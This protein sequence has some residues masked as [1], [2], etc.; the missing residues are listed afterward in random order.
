MNLSVVIPVYNESESLDSLHQALHAAL[1]GLPELVWEVVYVDDGSVDG[2]L[3]VLER[4]AAADPCRSP[5]R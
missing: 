2:S 4:L 1:D 5:S 3:E